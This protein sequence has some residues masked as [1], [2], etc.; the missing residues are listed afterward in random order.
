MYGSNNLEAEEIDEV[1]E[2]VD[3]L[4][5]SARSWWYMEKDPVK[6]VSA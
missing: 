5:E 2:T 1:T 4:I 6:K 3:D